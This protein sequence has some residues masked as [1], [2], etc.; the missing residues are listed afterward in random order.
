VVNR[1]PLGHVIKLFEAQLNPKFSN[2]NSCPFGP[3]KIC[4]L[5]EQYSIYLG[6][7]INQ[8]VICDIIDIGFY[9]IITFYLKIRVRFL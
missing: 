5:T 4:F 7:A 9:R 8:I 3:Q 6:V 1:G 2:P